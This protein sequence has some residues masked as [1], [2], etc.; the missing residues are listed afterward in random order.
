MNF[1]DFILEKDHEEHLESFSD[2]VSDENNLGKFFKKVNVL[3]DYPSDRSNFSTFFLRLSMIFPFSL[4]FR[5]KPSIE[6]IGTDTFMI[7]EVNFE[8]AFASVKRFY[9][10]SKRNLICWHGVYK[11][12]ILGDEISLRHIGYKFY[13]GQEGGDAELLPIAEQNYMPVEI[14]YYVISGVKNGFP[15]IKLLSIFN[16]DLMVT[17]HM[18]LH[19]AE[20]MGYTFLSEN[21]IDEII[22]SPN[23]WVSLGNLKK[24]HKWKIFLRIVDMNCKVFLRVYSKKKGLNPPSVREIVSRLKQRGIVFGIQ[25]DVIKRYL[26]SGLFEDECLA[27]HSQDP[28]EG[29]D[30][31]IEE[32]AMQ[33][34]KNKESI[35]EQE[36]IFYGFS[37]FITVKKGDLVLR[38]I[39]GKKS[40]DG[41][42]VFGRVLKAKAVS[43]GKEALKIG[44]GLTL[45]EDG[46]NIYAKT[47]GNLYKNHEGIWNV[48]SVLELENVGPATGDVSHIGSVIVRDSVHDGFRLTVT[49]NVRVG[50]SVGSSVIEAGGNIDII[51]G[52]H[53]KGKGR[54][55]SHFGSVTAKFILDA[56]VVAEKKVVVQELLG[57]CI[58][59]AGFMVEAVNLRSAIWGGEINASW[60]VVATN[61]GSVAEKKTLVAVG[62]SQALRLKLLKLEQ[63]LAALHKDY[64]KKTKAVGSTGKSSDS[65]KMSFDLQKKNSI[66][67]KK[68]RQLELERKE[69]KE[70]MNLEDNFSEVVVTNIFYGGVTVRC[71]KAELINRKYRKSVVLT[72]DLSDKRFVKVSP[73][74]VKKN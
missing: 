55:K 60:R 46:L 66:L 69:I 5:E 15:S 58:V 38:R 41:I 28:V 34:K 48:E 56:A 51:L 63:K 37:K 30:E 21:K 53:G 13:L 25:K 2:K 70:E 16:D 26:E 74:I 1:K 32:V 23:S 33:S 31:I 68:I 50:K 54:L 45:S 42:D 17:K 67:L 4:F 52:M 39:P 65:K 64:V 59:H 29:K 24:Q 14:S 9:P 7:R 10:I 8:K 47:G 20:K 61:I 27:A 57:N 71:N 35:N 12:G 19:L 62:H 72:Q 11:E 44:S 40:K 3:K 43:V 36:K 22:K 73:Y 49:G 6:F 18:I